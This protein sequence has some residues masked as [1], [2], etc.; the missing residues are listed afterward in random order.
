[1]TPTTVTVASLP[2]T[3]QAAGTMKYVY[4]YVV[5]NT[6]AAGVAGSWVIRNG[7]NTVTIMEVNGVAGAAATDG[8]L[9]QEP[10]PIDGLRVNA[11]GTAP[12]NQELVLMIR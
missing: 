11:G 1:M 4:G 9:W 2:N 6:G 12:T 8:F 5:R 10:V 7:G 3:I